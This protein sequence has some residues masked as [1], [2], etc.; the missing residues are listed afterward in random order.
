LPNLRVTPLS[1][2]GRPPCSLPLDDAD[3][4]LGNANWM[5]GLQAMSDWCWS[6]HL[7][8]RAFPNNLARFF[9][10]TPGI[11]EQQLNF[12]TT[13]IFDE[14]S[15]RNGIQISGFLDGVTRELAISLIAQTR[16]CWYSMTHHAV[17]GQLRAKKHGM[18]DSAFEAKWSNLTR[19]RES[20]GVYTEVE[21]AVLEFAEAF[22]T[23]PKKFGD[24]KYGQLRKVLAQANDV[25]YASEGM[26]MQRLKMARTAWSLAASSGATR[27]EADKAA[28]QA[29]AQVNDQ[30]PAA[31]AEAK[32]NAQIIELVFVCLQ[33]VALS[34][35]LTA[36][37]I[38]DEPFLAGVMQSSLPPALIHQMNTLCSLSGKNMPALV[39]DAVVP[40]I[41]E[42][43]AGSVVVQPSRPVSR[44]IPLESYEI[45]MDRDLDKGLTVGG[46]QVGTYGWSFGIHFPGNLVYCLMLHPE[47]A[48]YEPP[49]SLPLLFNEDE[50]RNGV[51]TSGYVSRVLKELVYQ[52][53]YKITRSRYGLEHHTMFLF[54]SYLDLYGVGRPPRPDLSSQQQKKAR[55]LA[56]RRAEQAV[57]HIQDH[58]NAP[59]GVFSSME[60]AV[61]T[62]VE[63]FL[64]KPHDAH[65]VERD[66]R[67]GLDREN[68][69]EITASMRIL[70]TSPGLGQRAALDRLLNHQVAELAML[71]G[72]MDGLARALT[73]LQLYSEGPV[74]IVEG[75]IDPVT[76]GITP[77]LTS[78][79]EVKPTGYFNTRPALL[80]FM[81][82]VV[83]VTAKAFTVNEL[84]VNPELNAEIRRRLNVG[85]RNIHICASIAER[86]AEF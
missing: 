21:F 43:D 75:T 54:N 10:H 74:Q 57:L 33:F 55:E 24:A 70:D 62:W 48:R 19:F 30:I 60:L 29:A 45:K 80:D 36:L 3:L 12:S 77:T 44:R 61:L 18:S 85:E 15:F 67:D 51:Q 42:I 17:L 86:T 79:G 8:P 28:A 2:E 13:L 23:N 83:G 39:P 64:T 56:I 1:Q 6:G 50:W 68:Q 59:E 25:R 72:H 73:S 40:P 37:N 84:M 47:L 52:K 63:A 53:I 11:F 34:G 7:N 9:L 38:P 82:E 58:N 20:R 14:P 31:V 5:K 27:E 49:Y 71:T 41:R 65:L 16:R 26:W 35:V 78:T 66:M 22:A 69:R 76:S 32:L 81:R 46:V 4:S